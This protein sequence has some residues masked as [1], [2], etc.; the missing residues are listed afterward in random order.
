MDKVELLDDKKRVGDID[1]GG[2]LLAVTN[3]PDMLANAI[4]LLPQGSLRQQKKIK[5]LV[6]AGMGGSA[7][8]G[9][10]LGSLL[11]EKAPFPV[12]VN[13]SYYS[14][15]FVDK[16]TVFFAISYSGNTEETLGATK[17][18]AKRGAKIICITSGGALKKLAEQH[19]FPFYLIPAGFQPRAALPYLLAPILNAVKALGLAELKEKELQE[20]LALLNELKDEYGL[21]KPVRANLAK[22]TAQK[23]LGKTPLVFASVGITDSVGLRFKTQLNENSKI[24][25]AINLFPELNHNEI[26]ALAAL[27]RN[28]HNYSLLFLRDEKD[29]ERIKKRMEITKSLIGNQLGGVNQIWSKGKS[30]LARILSLIYLGDF[31]SVYLAILQGIDPTP[32]EA[33]TRLKKELKR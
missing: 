27:K 16:E 28:Q 19:G 25:A 24:M 20:T 17:E 15:A 13:R 30:R 12:F 5:Q 10:I 31:V 6:V 23:L 33:I 8:A 11:R 14:P 21:E 29:S 22:Q 1:K 32:V 9:D 4:G 2:M 3:F 7:I 26:V 18:A